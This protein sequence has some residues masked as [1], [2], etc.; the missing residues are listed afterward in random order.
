MWLHTVVSRFKALPFNPECELEVKLKH[1]TQVLSLILL[2]V[3]KLD[4]PVSP[5]PGSSH[6]ADPTDLRPCQLVNHEGNIDTRWQVRQ[7]VECG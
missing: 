6:P 5:T 4:E 7:A 1:S 2:F 3:V